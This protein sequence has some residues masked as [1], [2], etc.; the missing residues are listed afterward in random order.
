[1]RTQGWS[2]LA[3]LDGDFAQSRDL[4][5]VRRGSSCCI[6][7]RWL[8]EI[9]LPLLATVGR[10]LLAANPG[11]SGKESAATGIVFTDAAGARLNSSPADEKL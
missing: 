3:G 9:A 5:V 1:V 2:G 7:I 10:P 8:G 6:L 4:Y 11:A